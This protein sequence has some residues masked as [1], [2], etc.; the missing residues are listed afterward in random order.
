MRLGSYLVA[1]QTIA[2][3]EVVRFMRIWLQ[4]VPR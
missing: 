3:K 4:T 1:Y 2:V